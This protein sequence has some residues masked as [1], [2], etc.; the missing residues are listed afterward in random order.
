M[1]MKAAY[2]TACNS[3]S[4]LWECL[5]AGVVLID[6]YTATYWPATT[7]FSIDLPT[8]FFFKKQNIFSLRF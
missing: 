2:L 7:A 1:Q 5:Y 4:T 8:C 3:R 6:S